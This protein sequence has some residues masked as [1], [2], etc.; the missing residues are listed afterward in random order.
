MTDYRTLY[1][2]APIGLWQIRLNDGKILSANKKTCDILGF[3]NFQELSRKS[4]LEVTKNEDLIK[5]LHESGE[6]KNFPFTLKKKDGKEI[7]ALLSL[8]LSEDKNYVEGSIRDVTEELSL[9]SKIAPHIQKM[10]ILRQSIIQKLESFEP[11]YSFSK[12]L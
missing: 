1:E 12:S 5:E 3:R 4:I 9:E 6:I 7:S 10:S 11:V 8:K 2:S